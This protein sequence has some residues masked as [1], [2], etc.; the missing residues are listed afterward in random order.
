MAAGGR[1]AAALDAWIVFE[2][3]SGSSMTPPVA[4]TWA[5]R[6]RTPVIRVCG[7]SRRRISSAS[8]AC[9]KPGER[10]RLIYRPR[11]DDRQRDSRKSFA[12][13]DYRDLLITAHQQLGRPIVLVWDNLNVHLAYGL[14]QFVARQDWLT[15]HQL[16]SYAPYLNPVEGIWSL[17]RRGWLSNT[18]FATPEHLIQTIRHG[19]RTIQ[20]RPRLIDGY[21][22]GIGLSLTPTTSCVQAQQFGNRRSEHGRPQTISTGVRGVRTQA[23][24]PARVASGRRVRGLN[25]GLIAAWFAAV[26]WH[27]SRSGR[28]RDQAGKTID[29]PR[30]TPPNQDRITRNARVSTGTASDSASS[31]CRTVLKAHT[32][33]QVREQQHV[34]QGRSSNA[35]GCRGHGEVSERWDRGS[36]ISADTG[37]AAGPSRIMALH[38]QT[39]ATEISSL[40]QTRIHAVLQDPAVV[41]FGG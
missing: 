2:N 38:C 32:R 10:S 36:V 41:R 13:T 20:Y 28:P 34:S 27:P 15:V 40:S 29:G 11:C 8:L 23:V 37:S 18:A 22:A 31:K 3:E 1:T 35:G 16:P 21:L 33:S 24:G 4:R 17:L 5:R 26:R 7:R 14:R 9:Y 30:E 12:W 25:G 6:G 19:L 39:A